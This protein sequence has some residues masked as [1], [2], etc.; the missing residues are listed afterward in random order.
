MTRE[1]SATRRYGVVL[2]VIL[3]TQLM[4]TLDGTV[5]S[6]AIP[7]I[8]QTL[9]FSPADLSW[10]QNAYALAFGG[11]LLLGARAGD[12]LGRRRV[13]IVGVG[14][15][16]FASLCGGLAPTAGS[17][18]AAR[19]VQ[20]LGA[21]IAAPAALAFLMLAAGEGTRRLKALG[22]YSLVNSGGASVGLLLGGVLTDRLSWRWGLFINVPIG[23]ALMI[24]A[25]VVL[26]R[27]KR[28]TGHFDGAG[29]LTSTVG[30]TA[31]VY[32]L[33]RAAQ[34]GWS[35]IEVLSAFGAG[36]ILLIAFVLIERR[37]SHPVVPLKL[38]AS[39]DRDSS[40]LSMLLL[41][42][43]LLGMFFFL[44]QYMQGVLGF[45]PLQAGLG[46]LPLTA[47]LLIMTRIVPR[48]I[49]WVGRGLLTVL[50]SVV[51]LGGMVWLSQV[52]VHS[53]YAANILGPLVLF[54]IGAGALFIPLT[55]RALAH[56]RP[57]HAGAASGMLNVTQQLGGALGLG[58][59]VTIFGTAIRGRGAMDSRELLTRGVHQA[60]LGA[61]G[62]A[63][64][65]LLVMVISLRPWRRRKNSV[66]TEEAVVVAD[67]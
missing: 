46:F 3:I 17:L 64:I 37:A 59:L 56:V 7:K 47:L 16:T 52:T 57:E 62:F 11:L 4:V 8:E 2:T 66:G 53:S 19:V 25:R 54:G 43:T 34:A 10:V 18:L 61:T 24:T 15:F 23:I 40:Y 6:V 58:V 65:T 36:S 26:P 55:G 50:G 31:I 28:E 51:V 1:A 42:G 41:V 5:I 13:F 35:S 63:V 38:F 67:A 29:A 60:Y 22:L 21:A 32:G 48:L 20:G 27:A 30:V 45:T 44:T 49:G 39:F 14:V 9:H 12:L 33:I